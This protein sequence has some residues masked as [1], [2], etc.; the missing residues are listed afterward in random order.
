MI[1][2][3]DGDV[4]APVNL[5]RR[6]RQIGHHIWRSLCPAL[7]YVRWPGTR[8]GIQDPPRLYFLTGAGF[9]RRSPCFRPIFPIFSGFVPW[10]QEPD[11]TW[12]QT[13]I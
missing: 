11:R 7:Q 9:G 12:F 10:H 13:G 5:R 3:N 4:R 1:D 6:H 8:R 2:E